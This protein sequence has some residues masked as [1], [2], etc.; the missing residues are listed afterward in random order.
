[1]SK[2]VIPIAPWHPASPLDRNPLQFTYGLL[3][4]DNI[5]FMGVNGFSWFADE[6]RAMAY[7]RNDVW[8]DLG[9]SLCDDIP[10]RAL[11][12][13]LL[14]SNSGLTET[15]IDKLNDLQTD[16]QIQW[17][18]WFNDLFLGVDTLSAGFVKD[19]HQCRVTGEV[20]RTPSLSN[21][22]EAY[23]SRFRPIIPKQKKKV[24]SAAELAIHH[25]YRSPLNA[26]PNK[27]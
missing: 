27:K 9:Y 23:L 24:L 14:S 19:F 25:F 22:F 12:R 1:M 4:I 16:F 10:T 17:F 5:H 26:L 21:D 20:Q 7:L 2:S 18:G 6:A 11:F 3:L 8:T 15:V 13:T